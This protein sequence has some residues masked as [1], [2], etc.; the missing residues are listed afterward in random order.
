MFSKNTFYRKIKS[1]QREQLLQIY[2]SC[3][4]EV[5]FF[6]N[7]FRFYVHT[8]S[9][10][11][12]K[13][14]CKR[15]TDCIIFQF[16]SKALGVPKIKSVIKDTRIQ[17]LLPD[18]IKPFCPLTLYYKYDIPMGRRIFNY[19]SFLKNLDNTQIRTILDNDCSCSHSPYIYEPHGHII[20]GN[21]DIIPDNTLRL[22]LS[23]GTKFREPVYL[24][25]SD[26]F[27]SLSNDIEEFINKKGRKYRLRNEEFEEWKNEVKRVLKNRIHFFEEH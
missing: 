25:S 16:S 14:P 7:V 5:G 10:T 24:S 1:F 20:T 18:C 19:S 15:D 3:G 9:P 12:A 8:F 4:E 17:S 23:Y 22:L 27:N 6:F 11:K 13:P 26:L 21:L 2:N